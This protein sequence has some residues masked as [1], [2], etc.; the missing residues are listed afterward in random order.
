MWINKNILYMI[1]DQNETH[2]KGVYMDCSNNNIIVSKQEI[3]GISL[4]YVYKILKNQDTVPAPVVFIFHR[5]LKSK[6]DELPLAFSLAEKGFFCI[7]IDMHGHGERKNV[8]PDNKYNF[9]YIFRDMFYTANDVNVVLQHLETHAVIPID[10]TNISSIGI[11]IGS[12]IAIITSYLNKEIKNVVSIIGNPYGWL[13]NISNEA[14]YGFRL[15]AATRP[16]FQVEKALDDIEL[17][18]PYKHFL[19]MDTLPRLLCL[20]GVLDMSFKMEEIDKGINE[21]EQIYK[22]KGQK[23]RI[24]KIKYKR[25]GHEMVDEMID[26]IDIWLC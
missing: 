18:D 17:C 8:L 16:I 12:S 3:K 9:N 15:Y 2:Y 24:H 10:M 13:K 20:N 14:F 22:V 25:A 23:D 4:L 21:M 1:V 7:L 6:K 5:L 19:C 11:S 26:D